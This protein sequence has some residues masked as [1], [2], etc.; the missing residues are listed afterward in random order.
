MQQAYTTFRP[1]DDQEQGSPLEIEVHERIHD[2]S[3]S[4]TPEDY[5]GAL[6]GTRKQKTR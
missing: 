5:E 3:V 2:I 4:D 1:C 6:A